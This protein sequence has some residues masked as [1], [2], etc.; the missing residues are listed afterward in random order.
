[1]RFMPRLMWAP[2]AMWLV[3]GDGQVTITVTK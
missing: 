2:L 3:V 1:M